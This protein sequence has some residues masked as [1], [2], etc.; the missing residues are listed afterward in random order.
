MVMLSWCRKMSD[1]EIQTYMKNIMQCGKVQSF[2]CFMAVHPENRRVLACSGNTDKYLG[3][4]WQE[5]LGKTIESLFKEST[6]VF[7]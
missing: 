7:I 3:L 5:V 4:P 2:G 1:D 6:K